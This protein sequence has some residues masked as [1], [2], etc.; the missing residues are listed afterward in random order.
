MSTSP[1]LSVSGVVLGTEIIMINLLLDVVLVLTQ[2][3][4]WSEGK[5]YASI[6]KRAEA[7]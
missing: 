7:Q 3:L 6:D 1:E 5:Y 4:V 2:L